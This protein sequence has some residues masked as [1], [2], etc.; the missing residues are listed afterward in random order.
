MTAHLL[1]TSIRY[2]TAGRDNYLV[3]RGVSIRDNDD[4]IKWLNQLNNEWVNALKSVSP[5]ILIEWIAAAGKLQNEL[6]KKVNLFEQ[7]PFPVSW[8]GESVSLNW[9]HMARE[10]TERWHHQQQIRD[11][12][13][14][15]AL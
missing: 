11:A 5:A 4:L 1:D 9:F 13:N 8:A 2:I 10:Y 3:Q 6:L 12:V 14:K 15:P 7:A